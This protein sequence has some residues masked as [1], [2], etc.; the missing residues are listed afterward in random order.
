MYITF[1]KTTRQKSFYVDNL[2]FLCFQE[3]SWGA[4]SPT[5]TLQEPEERDA[6]VTR[7]VADEHH[8]ADASGAAVA[9][10][11]GFGYAAPDGVP[12]AATRTPPADDSASVRPAARHDHPPTPSPTARKDKQW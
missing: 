9:G 12:A 6:T 2:R 5:K 11:E 4:V 1:L 10:R 7:A 8:A 3:I